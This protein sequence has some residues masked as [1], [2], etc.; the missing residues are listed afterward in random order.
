MAALG[1]VGTLRSSCL[2]SALTL[3]ASAAASPSCLQARVSLQKVA[4][5]LEVKAHQANSSRSWDDMLAA[6]ELSVDGCQPSGTVM[7][8]SELYI[9][10]LDHDDLSC[11]G[12]SDYQELYLENLEGTTL[13]SFVSLQYLDA[14]TKARKCRGW[15]LAASVETGSGDFPDYQERCLESYEGTMLHRFESLKRPAAGMQTGNC[16][17]QAHATNV[18]K[19]FEDPQLMVGEFQP[20]HVDE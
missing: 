17:G 9:V 10:E 12:L 16:M 15:M 5:E 4:R 11:V 19:G 8:G 20:Q 13:S 6:E 1:Q 18:E 2:F 7:V 14:D 3:L